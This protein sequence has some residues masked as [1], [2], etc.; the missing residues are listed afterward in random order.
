MKKSGSE[1]KATNV[2]SNSSSQNVV[3]RLLTAALY[4]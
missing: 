3:R 2:L 1:S 4:A